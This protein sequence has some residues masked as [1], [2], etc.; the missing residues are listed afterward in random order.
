[1]VER[2]FRRKYLLGCALLTLVLAGCG[3]GGPQDAGDI[4]GRQ[5]PGSPPDGIPEATILNI[6]DRTRA[7]GDMASAISF[8]R[9]AHAM[10]PSDP[11]PL[12]GL[13]QAL[14]RLGLPNEA[15]EAYREALHLDPKNP[16]ALRGLAESLVALNQPAA[17][18]EAFHKAIAAAPTARAYDGLGVAEDLTGDFTAAEAAYRKGLALAPDDLALRNNLGLSLAL[19]GDSK[20]AIDILRTVTTDPA[21]SPRHRA[22]LA[23]ALG[24]A[25]RMDEAAQ[26][27]RIDLDERAVR[28]NLA[29]YAELRQLSPTARAQ[30][31]LR[32][33]ADPAPSAEDAKA[34]KA[35]AGTSSPAPLAAAPVAS[36]ESRS[37]ASAAGAAP[38]Q[39]GRDPP[40]KAP[41]AAA[42][43]VL[44]PAHATPAE[45]GGGQE[46]AAAT[47][48]G[49]AIVG[50]DWVQVGAS[51]TERKAREIW[52]I[53]EQHNADLVQGLDHVV[54]RVERK[55]GQEAYYRVRIGP[56][57]SLDHA[58]GL[59]AALQE[60]HV[61]C[62]VA[63]SAG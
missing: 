22:N 6:A 27:A 12:V 19:A 28:S 44:Q 37:L 36:V 40:R 47:G 32:P 52:S 14:D 39:P 24:L 11:R 18:V 57:D 33:S 50:K 13:G 1:M 21:A 62:F 30:A 20:A 23:L 29:Y 25:G 31:I 43:A 51:K 46:A 38:P 59:C 35:D 3:F 49:A 56:L 17:A 15:M 7:S 58:K 45:A 54:Q 63:R 48:G 10:A 4:A 42:I 41:Q 55:T 34:E 9:R 26:V 53:I 60:R 16:D 2:G 5:A 8:Y 61:G